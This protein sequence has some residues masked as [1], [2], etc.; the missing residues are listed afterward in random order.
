[1]KNSHLKK[2]LIIFFIAWIVLSCWL[3]TRSYLFY[4]WMFDEPQKIRFHAVDFK[5]YY[6]IAMM[7]KTGNPKIY[8]YDEYYDFVRRSRIRPVPKMGIITYPPSFYFMMIPLTRY[9]IIDAARIW[10]YPKF[11]ALALSAYILAGFIFKN[12][13]TIVKIGVSAA[14]FA[15]FITFS[16]TLDELIY[17]QVNI[18]LLTLLLFSMY[19]TR[20]K[21]DIASGLVLGIIFCIK[22]I[23]APLILYFALKKRWRQVGG[24]IASIILINLPVL[25]LYG[26]RIYFDYFQS[27]PANLDASVGVQNMSFF[28][29]F[30][31]LAHHLNFDPPEIQTWASASFYAF[32]LFILGGSLYPLIFSIKKEDCFEYFAILTTAAVLIAP[33]MFTYHHVWLF[34]PIGY[35][36]YRIIKSKESKINILPDEIIFFIVYFTLSAVDGM[37]G[38][39]DAYLFREKFLRFSFPFFITLLLW[40]DLVI[41]RVT[42]NVRT[43][44]QPTE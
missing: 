6:A 33:V 7:M 35:L 10:L 44:A 23:S 40:G 16:P 24:A 38:T 43:N 3:F 34:I 13:K 41:N 17:G 29:K 5:C 39:M 36:A 22:F 18:Y 9:W 25:M 1:M 19:L 21:M 27:L 14:F 4:L 42:E 31:L 37:S 11:F 30:Y 26:T 32:V 28:S 12:K 2:F 8:S 15:A 20:K